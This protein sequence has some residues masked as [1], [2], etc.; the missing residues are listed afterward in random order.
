MGLAGGGIRSPCTVSSL[1]FLLPP[2]V[3]IVFHERAETEKSVVLDA[4]KHLVNLYQ[5]RISHYQ[6]SFSLFRLLDR[7]T[8][9]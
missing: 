8:S 6:S 5:H 1:S 4:D 9:Y 7:W 2:H 3:K